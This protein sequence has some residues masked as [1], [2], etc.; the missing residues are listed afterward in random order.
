MKIIDPRILLWDGQFVRSNCNNNFKDEQAKKAKKYND[1]DAGYGRHNGIK[2]GVGY[3]TSN[4]FAYCGSWTRVLPVYF[5]MFSANKNENPIFRET[6]GNFLKTPIGKDWML[7]ILDT[8]GYSERSLQFC[9]EKRV[10][11]LIRAK[12]GL[13]NQPTREMKKGFYF[14][15]KYI[16]KEWSDADILKTYAIRPA[17]EAGQSANN[18]FY[19]SQRLNTR[20]KAMAM[21]N[22]GLTNILSLVRAITAV[23]LGRVDLMSKL[24]AFSSTREHID[25]H[26]WVKMAHHSSFRPLLLPSLNARQKEFWDRSLA[27]KKLQ[28]KNGKI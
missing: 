6:L 24:S 20:G 9:Q 25:I 23:K 5:E 19:N 21:I 16:P 28:E 10:F 13:I 14:N 22:R 17:I 15:T 1:P 18:T 2:K 7:V 11:P 26:S 8:G 12:K 27:K 3:T 4:L